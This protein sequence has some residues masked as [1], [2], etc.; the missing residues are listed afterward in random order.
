MT[1][2]LLEIGLVSI[3]GQVTLLREIS[4]A[5]FGSELIYIL[6]MGIWLLWTAAGAAAG[7]R[8]AVPS[9]WR[10][11]AGLLAYALLLPACV[12]LARAPHFL[13]DAVPG[14]YLSFPRQLLAMGIALLPASVLGGLLFQWAAKLLV[15]RPGGRTLALAYAVESSG[16][17][18][19]GIRAT[20]LL[21]WGVQNF[22]TG[23]LCG[24]AAFAAALL[25]WRR[26][27]P[28]WLVPVALPLAALL[29]SGIVG[30]GILDQA[31]TAL[32]HPDLA[33][34]RDTPY[35]RV[36]VTELSGQVSVFENGA[37]AYESE[38]TA[39]EEFVHL[40]AIQVGRPRRVL[41]LGGASMGLRRE[42]LKYS[43]ERLDT[44]ELNGAL[45]DLLARHLP[46]PEPPSPGEDAIGDPRR[47]LE[48]TGGYDLILV[49]M[50]EPDSAQANRFYTVE[51][52]ALSREHLRPGGVLALRLAGSENLWTPAL[53]RR[54]A[55]IWR[56]VRAEFADVLVLPGATN[57]VLASASPLVRDPDALATRWAARGVEARLVSP[58]YIRYLLT[59]DRLAAIE[60][61]LRGSRA[62]MNADARPICYQYTLVLW[63][64]RFFPVLALLDL[65]GSG[66][67]S[68][69]AG[70]GWIVFPA[71]AAA[72]LFLLLRWRAGVRR[73]LLVG[74]AGLLGMVLESLLILNY[75]VKRGV[76]YQDIGLLLTLFMAGR[77][78]GSLALHELRRRLPGRFSGGRPVGAV[79]L[80]AFAMLNAL[81]ASMLAEGV[82]ANLAST[83]LLLFLGGLFV[84]AVFAFATLHE[85]KSQKAVVSPLYAADLLG[86][87]AGSLLAGLLLVPVLG[88]PA[89]AVLL[90]ALAAASLL[91]I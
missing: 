55:S 24:A 40:A 78:L 41:I 28:R 17:L 49:G 87:C 38:G 36:T 85:V 50:P 69:G 53:V 90:A 13:L 11:R 35:G 20:L 32:R 27:R 5:F 44:V 66:E 18:A 67:G 65:P 47:F 56:A 86:G 21:R 29:G 1:F 26:G 39:A 37:L 2:W 6:A 25:P 46:A 19:G 23:L 81:V 51:F 88:L 52:F 70:W 45:A 10:V 59:N 77:A 22:L 3:L 7:R 33:E 42:A 15:G 60:R 68:E 8:A 63:L 48:A 62:P 76:L 54:T 31:L 16:G 83:S 14:A 12:A 80:S 71:A 43:V 4:A 84:G 91:L 34:S 61:D 89:T 75:Q 30:A 9:P 57:V 74:M 58:A 72:L 82:V 73:V 64:S 79:L